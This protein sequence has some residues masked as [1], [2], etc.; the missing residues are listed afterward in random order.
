MV[1]AAVTSEAKRKKCRRN[2]THH[3]K[4]RTPVNIRLKSPPSSPSVILLALLALAVLW[5]LGMPFFLQEIRVLTGSGL[6]TGN[7]RFTTLGNTLLAT[8]TV[9]YLGTAVLS[10]ERVG[11]WATR[12]AGAGALVLALDAVSHLLGIG[13]F[14]VGDGVSMRDAYDAISVLV[15]MLVFLYLL[16]EHAT[17]TRAGGVFVMPLMMCMIGAEIWLLAQGSGNRNFVADGFRAYWGHAYLVAHVIGFGAFV[18]A[19]C[20]GL[21]YLL[22]HYVDSRGD[23][24]P[25]LAQRLP[26]VWKAQSWMLSAIGAGV[27]VFVLALFLAVGW[28]LGAGPWSGYAL[29]KSLWI[30]AVLTFYGGMLVVLYTRSMTGLR[31]AW[32]TVAGLGLSLALFLGTQILTLGAPTGGVA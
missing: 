21:L 22:R 3:M 25:L 9:L 14:T 16:A 26:D 13:R 18:L 32:W 7:F 6:H 11:R 12:L 4:A 27:P 1:F 30:I 28:G 20:A 8:S 17:R 19:S 31:M 15:P 24:P 29:M 10:L 2:T 5:F 23:L